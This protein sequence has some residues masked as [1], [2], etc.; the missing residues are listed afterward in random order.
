MWLRIIFNW[1]ALFALGC[2]LV[3]M[4]VCVALGFAKLG[5]VLGGLSA[6]GVDLFL[7]RLPNEE[8]EKRWIHPEAGGHVWF[9]PAWVIG[10]AFAGL[11]FADYY[12]A[13]K[14]SQERL[15]QESSSELEFVDTPMLRAV[16]SAY[17]NTHQDNMTRLPRK[18]SDYLLDLEQAKQF[19]PQIQHILDSYP[20]DPVQNRGVVESLLK[21]TVTRI[22]ALEN[23]L[24]SHDPAESDEAK[25]DK[26][27]AIDYIKSLPG[28]SKAIEK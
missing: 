22:T 17:A 5:V 9:I 18:E 23:Y 26:L 6:V 16:V 10:V 12:Y 11:G 3:I 28:G 2:G 1:N 8:C 25:V 7:F 27:V 21:F 20:D 4:V 13:W 24:K 15:A 14:L 19:K